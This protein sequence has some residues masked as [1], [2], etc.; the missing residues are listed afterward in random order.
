MASETGPTSPE[1]AATMR[2]DD[3]L[4]FE[5]QVAPRLPAELAAALREAPWSFDFFQALRRIECASS[6]SARI[7][8]SSR[9]ADDSVRFGQ[10]PSLAFAPSTVAK[11]TPGRERLPPR[12]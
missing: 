9:T 4:P 11:Y 2:D 7:G 5:P 10:T 12:K 3:T 6:P 1:L 8:T